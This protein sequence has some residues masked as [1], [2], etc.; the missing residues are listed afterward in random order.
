MTDI[1][2]RKYVKNL[3]FENEVQDSHFKDLKMSS[4]PLDGLNAHIQYGICT[5]PGEKGKDT[6]ASYAHDFDT[7]LL[8]IGFDTDDL[9]KLGA[10][11]EL[12]LGTEKEKRVFSY[13]SAVAIPKGFPYFPLNIKKVDYP[14]LFMEISLTRDWH[15]NRF[16][17]DKIPQGNTPGNY[18]SRII[19]LAFRPKANFY[20]SDTMDDS[21]GDITIIMGEDLGFDLHI[22]YESIKKA[23]YVF[24][25]VPHRGHAHK[26]EECVLLMGADPYAPEILGAEA[27]EIMGR[28]KEEHIISSP[29]VVIFPKRFPH[30]PLKITKVEHPFIFMVVSLAAEHHKNESKYGYK[31]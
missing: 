21:G 24:G 13:S 17:L 27:V 30:G 29:V 12:C 5:K 15:V 25:P 1:K 10:E 8:F 4:V 6:D 2:Y 3:S 7:V 19:E 26:F 9:T 20:G 22:Y 28:E 18:K 16:I 23:P 14:F 11:V 31:K